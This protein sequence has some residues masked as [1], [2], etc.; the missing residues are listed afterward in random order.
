[1]KEDVRTILKKYR[2]NIT[3]TRLLVL[4][5]FLESSEPLTR[6]HFFNETLPDMDRTSIFRT[7][8][9]FVEKNIIYRLPGTDGIRR[10]SLRQATNV[11]HSNFICSSCKKIIPLKTIMLPEVELPDNYTQQNMEIV[12]D[13]LCD[14]CRNKQ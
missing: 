1:M 5:A 13:G 12:I 9:L 14:E 10:Y 3:K 7:L 4:E 11:V 2:V 6:K 8:N